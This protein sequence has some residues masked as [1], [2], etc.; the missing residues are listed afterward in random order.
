MPMTFRKGVLLT[1]LF[2]AFA[3]AQAKDELMK[4][5][6]CAVMRVAERYIV[7]KFPQFDSMKYS[8]KV[9]DEIVRWRVEYEL[10]PNMAGGT[11]VV[12]VDKKTLKGVDAYHTQ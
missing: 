6:E 1:V 12:F 4:D 9:F 11:P 8:P 7:K 10:P 3:L 5:V 2:H